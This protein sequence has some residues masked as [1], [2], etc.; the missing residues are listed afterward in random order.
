M[1]TDLMLYGDIGLDWWSGDG[2]T[3][4][5]VHASLQT[6]DPSASQHTVHINSVGG[7]VDTG[8]AIMNLLRAH[9]AQ[10][11]AVN[12]DFKL[13]T[14]C[15]GYAMSIASVIFMA[16]DIRTVALGGVVMI[17]EAWNGCYGNAAEMRKTCLLY[18]SPSPRD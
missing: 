12:P 2:I 6:L 5:Q 13:K 9:S 18:T 3:D 15:E 14:I 11:Q 17:H 8:L 7:R 10:M 4:E 16:G 1:S